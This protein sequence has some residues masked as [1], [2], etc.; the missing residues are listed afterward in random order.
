MSF[1]KKAAY[2]VLVVVVLY[3]ID[4]YLQYGFFGFGLPG[5]FDYYIRILLLIG[6][7]ITLAVGL[8]LIN[9]IAGQFSIGHAGFMAVGGYTAAYTT[10]TLFYAIYGSDA[11]RVLGGDGPGFWLGSAVLVVG[12]AAGALAAGLVGL[13]V[14]VPSLRLKGDYLAIVTLGFGEIIRVLIQNINV[15]GG[16]TGF[17]DL[18]FGAAA[19]EV[20][21]PV[22]PLATFFWI[23]L[24]AVFAIVVTRNIATSTIGRALTAVRDDEIAAEAMGVNTTYYKVLAFVVGSALAGVAGALSGHLFGN[25]LTP[26][27]FGFVRSIEV[28]TMI[29]LGG[30]GSITGSVVG[31]VALTI[32]PEALRQSGVDAAYP[33]LRMVIY[34]LLLI[35]LMI[36]RP[37][38]IFGRRELSL[39]WLFRPS[40]A[41]IPVALTGAHDSVKRTDA[42]RPV[43]DTHN[44]LDEG[45]THE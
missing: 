31:A 22:Q 3:A 36:F 5:S 4:H 13:L 41:A 10:C 44:S 19:N 21:V 20:V 30:I 7:N 35:L 6:I 2:C 24:A 29:V 26:A 11:P 43:G 42:A 40:K 9:G 18:T 34:A 38:G 25:L 45:D 39:A 16:N 23:F 14:G 37:Q 1:A 15:I 33:G 28:V 17:R 8:N 12:M 32:L 27:T